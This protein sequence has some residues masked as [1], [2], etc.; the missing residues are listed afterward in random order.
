MR[1]ICV[2]DSLTGS[3]ADVAGCDP[4][5][6]GRDAQ[7]AVER[8][9]PVTPF[10][11]TRSITANS[12]DSLRHIPVSRRHC[13][14]G[15]DAGP[16]RDHGRDPDRFGD[17]HGHPDESMAGL[18]RGTRPR[19]PTTAIPS[20]AFRFPSPARSR[21]SLHTPIDL[22]VE[23]LTGERR[24]GGT[25]S[26]RRRAGAKLKAP[27]CLAEPFSFTKPKADLG[28]DAIDQNLCSPN[29][30][31]QPGPRSIRCDE[32][33]SVLRLVG[34]SDT[35]KLGLVAHTFRRSFYHEIKTV[36]GA[37]SRRQDAMRVCREVLCFSFV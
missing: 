13:I 31:A 25:Q 14:A 16:V 20:G 6:L 27:A 35:P 32:M 37:L 22:A 28:C 5:Q 30:V 18:P 34:V 19:C 10:W 12:Y 36:E 4:R 9:A 24:W 7:V 11:K 33:R 29:R 15:C 8:D 2:W 26:P 1:R 23:H 17:R 21:A 3:V